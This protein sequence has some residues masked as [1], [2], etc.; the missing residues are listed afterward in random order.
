MLNAWL[1]LLA[2]TLYL[3]SVIGL[4]AM[5]LPS[6]RAI[7][8]DQERLNLLARALKLYNPLQIG[9]LGLVVL[10]GAF[11]VTDLKAAYRG[12]FAQQIG[13]PLALKLSLS[14]VLIILS[15]YQAMGVA[16]RF[17]KRYEAGESFPHIELE[18]IIRRLKISAIVILLLA[19]PIL[20]LGARLQ[21][22]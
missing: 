7:T 9:A 12:S 22:G 11:Q 8:L 5:L 14:F 16:H 13:G 4:W 6:V 15:T 2:I 1:H 18:R 20:W 3:G 21:E 19:V 17:V 10:T